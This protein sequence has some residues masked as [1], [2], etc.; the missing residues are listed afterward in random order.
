[1]LPV[2]LR[3]VSSLKAILRYALLIA[4]YTF[5]FKTLTFFLLLFPSKTELLL[6]IAIAFTLTVTY[7]SLKPNFWKRNKLSTLSKREKELFPLL[8]SG[9]S[10]KTICE[11][12]HIAPSTL[13]SH[14]NHIYKKLGVDSRAQLAEIHFASST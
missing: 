7:F 5:L 6:S 9:K 2:S 12:L 10:N 11:E 3:F 4:V 1:M 14:I 8:L 13:K